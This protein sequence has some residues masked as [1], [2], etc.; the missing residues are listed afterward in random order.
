MV[1]SNAISKT[2]VLK[3][4]SHPLI[5]IPILL[6]FGYIFGKSVA[7]PNPKLWLIVFTGILAVVIFKYPQAGIWTVFISVFFLDWLNRTFFIIP[8][9]ITWLKDVAI[10]L[11][12]L[13]TVPMVIRRHKLVRTP[14]DLPVLFFVLV[15]IISTFINH[16]SPIVAF[17]GFRKALKY[18]LLFYIIVNTGFNEQFLKKIVKAFI[19]V[20]F[21][22]VP[23]A[24]VEYLLWNPNLLAL[25]P[26]MNR[27]D[28]I[29]GTFP[30]GGTG[31]MSLYLISIMCFL[32]AYLIYGG[33]KKRR[34]LFYLFLL[35]IPLP[36]AM[37]RASFIFL[38]FVIVFMFLKNIKKHFVSRFSYFVLFSLIFLGVVKITYPLT[39]Y[40]L[41]NYLSNPQRAIQ[42]QSKYSEN[43]PGRINSIQIIYDELSNRD[44]GVILG[45]G[46]GQW[47]ESYFGNYTGNIYQKF[48]LDFSGINQ[49]ASTLSEWGILGLIA[50]FLII[51]QIYCMNS[52]FFATTKDDF[53]RVISYGF[54]GI[55]FLYVMSTLY[56]PL[57]YSDAGAFFFY[58]L[59]GSI[60][61]MKNNQK[62]KL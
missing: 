19:V 14:I 48:S 10:F 32:V 4:I 41:M 22:Q 26:A 7:Y 59:T 18:I 23:F 13:R 53:W 46:P 11:L 30:R 38:P 34:T 58:T 20:G 57:F 12:F 24:I 49:V 40:N 36:F 33:N 55:I 52:S 56:V 44:Y 17:M 1:K 28:F 2:D 51:L 35:F 50:L 43:N 5:Q 9:Q 31:L 39:G 25:G 54:S 61:I 21:I 37:S 8:R 60:F 15:G 16:S 6:L 3:I 47:S 42:M 27:W 45:A 62:E 29:T